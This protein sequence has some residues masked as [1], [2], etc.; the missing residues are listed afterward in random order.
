MNWLISTF[1][2]SVGK[3]LMMA[4]TGLCFMGFLTVHLIGNLTIYGGGDAFNDYA[5]KLHSFGAIIVFL[6]AGLVFFAAIHILTGLL[7]FIQNLKA[8]PTR[9]KVDKRAGGRTLSSVTMPYTGLLVLGFVIYH[10]INFTF[11]NKTGTTIFAIVSSSFGNPLTVLIYIA[12]MIIVALH[13]RHGFWSAAQTL[14]ANH[15]KYMPAIMTLS[16]IF[17]LVVGF[18]FGLLPIYISF[19]A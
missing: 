1:S 4:L 5:A 11:V 17:S 7:L 18:G 13:V 14:G 9:Y 10:L 2:S 19:F 15:P 16:I 3:K 8:R 6:N 12:A